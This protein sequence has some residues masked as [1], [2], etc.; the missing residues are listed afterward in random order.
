M[1]YPKGHICSAWPA[2]VGTVAAIAI[3]PQS[4]GRGHRRAFGQNA[5][6][7]LA[8]N[9]E[10]AGCSGDADAE[11]R[12]HVLAQ[13]GSGMR[14]WALAGRG[15]GNLRAF[16]SWRRKWRIPE[17]IIHPDR[18]VRRIPLPPPPAPSWRAAPDGVEVGDQP[19]R[20]QGQQA[21]DD[22]RRAETERQLD[23]YGIGMVPAGQGKYAED[24]EAGR[25]R[26]A[27]KPFGQVF[28]GATMPGI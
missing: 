14:G 7:R 27:P 6:E 11:R 3:E 5:L 18:I 15:H 28:F 26:A 10:I 21:G 23:D 24:Q 4:H 1:P 9:A 25:G 8:R 17:M 12:Q 16:G 13:K 2:K 20:G 22:Q 19:G